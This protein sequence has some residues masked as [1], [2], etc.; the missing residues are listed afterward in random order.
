MQRGK[1]ITYV[2]HQLKYYEHNYPTH[3]LVLAAVVFPLKIRRHYLYGER[4]QIFANHKN[5][6][7][8]FIQK[9]L[10]MRQRR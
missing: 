1:V 9:E 7:Y 4:I 3:D 5:L 10:N 8:L 6:K 2:S